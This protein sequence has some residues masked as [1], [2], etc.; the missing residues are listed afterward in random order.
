MI[1][2]FKYKKAFKIKEGKLW[3]ENGY[4]F[5]KL[6]KQVKINL[7]EIDQMFIVHKAGF[8]KFTTTDLA[9]YY[10]TDTN[11]YIKFDYIED[12]EAIDS[13]DVGA[14]FKII[15]DNIINPNF[16]Q[17]PV[18]EGGVDKYWLLDK[19]KCDLLFKLA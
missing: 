6:D 7:N 8:S 13:N 12:K 2:E 9:L 10:N 3:I 17:S 18:H 16:V 5:I 1:Y 19:E 11:L 4:L 14:I 15:K